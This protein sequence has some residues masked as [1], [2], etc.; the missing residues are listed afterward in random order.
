MTELGKMAKAPANKKLQ[1]TLVV[2]AILYVLADQIVV[3]DSIRNLRRCANFNGLSN[4]EYRI[5]IF[6]FANIVMLVLPLWCHVVSNKIKAHQEYPYQGMLLPFDT[7]QLAG[8]DALI[9]AKR[10]KK[11]V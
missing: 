5:C 11:R 1:I 2:L 4:N 7:E 3:G 9:F 8:S 6:F 10:L